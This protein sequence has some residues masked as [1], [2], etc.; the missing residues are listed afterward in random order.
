MDWNEEAWQQWQGYTR[1]GM[2]RDGRVWV[3]E[4]RYGKEGRQSECGLRGGTGRGQDRIVPEGRGI[5]RQ[6]RM[7]AVI[8]GWCRGCGVAVMARHGKTRRGSERPGLVRQG[9]AHQAVLP[10]LR[11]AGRRGRRGA[12]PCLARSGMDWRGE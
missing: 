6:S 8:K 7:G 11:V 10:R 2:A 4:A 12:R 1:S 9:L 5:E 3:G